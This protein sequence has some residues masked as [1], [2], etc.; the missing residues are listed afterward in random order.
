MVTN[1]SHRITTYFHTNFFRGASSET[2]INLKCV[3]EYSR[4]LT[5]IECLGQYPND[6]HFGQIEKKGVQ[7]Q[8]PINRTIFL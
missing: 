5:Q 8:N 6:Q 3:Y 2:G 7:S 1:Q 4:Q